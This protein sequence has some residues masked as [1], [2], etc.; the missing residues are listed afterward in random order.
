[1]VALFSSPLFLLTLSSALGLTL[2]A[3]ALTLPGLQPVRRQS[4]PSASDFDVLFKG[5]QAFRQEDPKLL[6]DLALNGQHPPFLFIGCSDS[7]VSEG[8]V[9]DANP[10]TFFAERNIANQY[11]ALDPNI[12]SN[13]AYG[14]EHLHVKHV[15][16]MGHYGCGG[17]AASVASAPAKPWDDATAAIQGWI[18]P[19][20]TLYAQSTRP[21]VV[22]L[23]ERNQGNTTIES[24]DLHDV[25]FRALIEENVKSTVSKIASDTIVIH[26]FENKTST[27]PIFFIHGW[28]YDIENGAVYDLDVSVG[29]PGHTIPAI[30]F[31]PPPAMLIEHFH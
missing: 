13:L 6:E 24:P 28:V 14:I 3:N 27:A 7:R 2:E 1:M 8:T 5:N 9:F 21:E 30:P 23:R 12:R 17:V 29:P 18:E 11:D 22:A 31:Q 26:A 20:R 10:G 19:I 15:I 25:G 4:D 16:V